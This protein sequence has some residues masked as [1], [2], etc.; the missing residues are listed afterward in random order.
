MLCLTRKPGDTIMIGDDIIVMV[1]RVDGDQVKIAIKAPPHVRIVRGELLGTP[2]ASGRMIKRPPNTWA[3]AL[4]GR[5][6]GPAATCYAIR[7]GQYG[8]SKCCSAE[9]VAAAE[10]SEWRKS[11]GPN[12]L[13]WDE[14]RD[15]T[16]A[17]K[18]RSNES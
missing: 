8:C 3:C 13:G 9:S 15:N 10:L 16:P 4:C 1:Y 6:Y 11:G 18:G 17:P 7:G 14:N 12:P 5:Q 2:G